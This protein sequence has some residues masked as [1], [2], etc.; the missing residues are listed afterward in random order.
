MAVVYILNANKLT[1]DLSKYANI[2]NKRLEK[3]KKSTNLLFIKEQLGS[4]LLLNDILENNYFKDINLLEYVYNESGKPYLKDKNLYFSLSHSN[5]IVALTVSKEEIGLDIELIK[6]IKESVAKRIMNENEYCIY[7]SLDKNK[8]ITYFYE[9]WTSKEAY[10]KK[11]GT[12]ISLN[13]SNIEIDED[14]LIKRIIID[15]NE[16]MLAVTNSMSLTIDE[17][18]IPKELLE[19]KK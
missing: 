1:T 17:R 19:R 8:K 10:V 16:Y 18:Y 11:L 9:V 14:I 6:P 7:S 4:N 3:I 12:S 15:N 5:G 13:P 2:D